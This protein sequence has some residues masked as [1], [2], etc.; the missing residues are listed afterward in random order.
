[1]GQSVLTPEESL[2]GKV[3]SGGRRKLSL[4]SLLTMGEREFG[5]DSETASVGNRG[6]KADDHGGCQGSHAWG[7]FSFLFD[8]AGAS[9]HVSD[10]DRR[11]N[12]KG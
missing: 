3:G 7:E 12:P 11:R 6:C 8:V 10:G 2:L 9:N 5:E 4:P 1:M